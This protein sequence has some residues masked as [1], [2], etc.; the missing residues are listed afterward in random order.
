MKQDTPTHNLTAEKVFEMYMVK[1]DPAFDFGFIF[2][3]FF[4][5]SGKKES[6]FQGGCGDTRTKHERIFALLYPWFKQQVAFGTGKGGLTEWFS[7]KFTADFYDN[8]KKVIYE[9]DGSS[10]KNP[11]RIN[12][13]KLREIFFYTERGIK[14]IRFTN[15]EVEDMFLER[16]KEIE[17][18]GKLPELFTENNQAM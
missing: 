9:I 6:N 2:D 7:K 8:E 18:A 5:G 11:R 16:L 4:G 3:M 1:L 17:S 15:K 13:D 10:H 14:T 12:K